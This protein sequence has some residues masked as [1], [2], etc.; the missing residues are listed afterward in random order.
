MRCQQFKVAKAALADGSQAAKAVGSDLRR[1]KWKHIFREFVGKVYVT[2]VVCIL[3]GYRRKPADRKAGE[4][5]IQH[6]GT[7]MNLV[8][9]VN[10]LSCSQ[11]AAAICEGREQDCRKAIAF[12]RFR[13]RR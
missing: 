9:Q 1:K 6:C 3:H 11:L 5:K 4:V 8:R 13:Q 12:F 7:I 2:S 10:R